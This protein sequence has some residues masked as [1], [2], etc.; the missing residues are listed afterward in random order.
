MRIYLKE[1]R[2]EKNIS[3][4]RLSASSGVA[5]SYIVRIEKGKANPTL[6]IM[7]KLAKELNVNVHTLFDCD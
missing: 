1:I 5:R 4:R 6:D 2:E 7:C 3:T